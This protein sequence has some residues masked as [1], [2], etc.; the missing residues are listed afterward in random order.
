MLVYSK[1][2][3]ARRLLSLSQTEIEKETSLSQRDISQLENGKKKFIPTVYIQY[4]NKAGVAL[5]MLFNDDLPL[6]LFE[7]ILS[8]TL[9]NKNEIN[10]KDCNLKCNPSCN[11]NSV[12]PP[13]T[14]KTNG[15]NNDDFKG[16]LKGNLTPFFM[17]NSGKTNSTTIVE[18]PVPIADDSE[19]VNV[20][21]VDISVAA[22]SGF[23]NPDQLS[24]IDSIRFPRSM[25]KGSST[26]LCVRIKGESMVP[27]LQ[28]GGYLVIRLLDRGEWQYINDGHVYVVSST[29][30]RA[31]VKRLKNRFHE[32][33]FIVCRSDNPDPMGYPSFNLMENEINTI[34]YAEWYISAK[35]PNIHATYYNKVSELED[36]YDDLERTFMDELRQMR[37]EIKVLSQ[38]S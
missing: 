3:S 36:K 38:P 32:H 17:P 31:F 20:P 21:V 13:Q 12:L 30:G 2:K 25:I 33:G 1:L 26:Y 19:M 29:D 27:T 28:D 4:L 18:L 11:L 7:E 24:E 23:Y 6:S 37:R 8:S 35:M 34:W 22:G 9:A 5:D 14:G 16:N 15:I 10:K